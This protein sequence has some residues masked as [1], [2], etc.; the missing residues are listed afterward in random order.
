MRPQ[1]AWMN[2]KALRYGMFICW[3]FSTF[4]DQEWTKGVKDVSFFNPSG[5][6]T[7]QWARVAKESGMTYILFLTKHHDGHCFGTPRRRTGRQRR[8]LWARTFWLR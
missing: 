6:D 7:D 4:S 5:M 1:L 2:S 3:S 8:G